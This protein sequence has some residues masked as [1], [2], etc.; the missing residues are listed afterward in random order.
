MSKVFRKKAG[1]IALALVAISSC[2]ERE[3]HR[4]SP[5]EARAFIY[6]VSTLR[7]KPYNSTSI[8]VKENK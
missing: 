6:A 8:E 1:V 5:E 2:R 3:P 7:I 4:M